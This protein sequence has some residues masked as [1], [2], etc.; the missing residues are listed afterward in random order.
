MLVLACKSQIYLTCRCSSSPLYRNMN[1][2]LTNFWD[3]TRDA[4][5]IVSAKVNSNVGKTEETVLSGEHLDDF[6][7][8]I[9][10]SLIEKGHFRSSVATEP[11]T[12]GGVLAPSGNDSAK[13]VLAS[14]GLFDDDTKILS[15]MEPTED[16]GVSERLDFIVV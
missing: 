14:E 6:V 12:K 2:S 4:S 16:D 11:Y 10:L 3:S 7:W 8:A 9:R 1:P 13:T 15:V 5:G